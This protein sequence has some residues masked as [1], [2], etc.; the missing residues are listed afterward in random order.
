MWFGETD[1]EYEF[2]DPSITNSEYSLCFWANDYRKFVTDI[3]RNS[4]F[5][6]TSHFKY[7]CLYNVWYISFLLPG[8]R[9]RLVKF[10]PNGHP[11]TS[12]DPPRS[13]STPLDPFHISNSPLWS[14]NGARW[15]LL[16]ILMSTFLLIF[17][18]KCYSCSLWNQWNSCLY[19]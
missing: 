17:I 10:V 12:L 18:P 11:S 16:I 2:T 3:Y 19:S 14:P 7:S 8:I 13:P 15:P 6:S 4:I 1:F 9:W 5:L